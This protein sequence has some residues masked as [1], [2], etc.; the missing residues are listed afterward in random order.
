MQSRRT[1]LKLIGLGGIALALP[2]Y[3]ST[4]AQAPSQ[5]IQSIYIRALLGHS[6][7]DN[8]LKLFRAAVDPVR[9]RVFVSGIMTPHIGILD[10]NNEEWIGTVNSGFD[11]GNGL[12]YLYYDAT[13]DWLFVFNS[14]NHILRTIDVAADSITGETRL[15]NIGVGQFLP[16]GERNELYSVTGADDGFRIYDSQNLA[17]IHSDTS[18]GNTLTSMELAPDGQTLYLLDALNPRIIHYDLNTRSPSQIIPIDL[19]RPRN[20]AY[21][22]ARNQFYIAVP[23]RFIAVVNAEGRTT[24]QL[25]IPADGQLQTSTYNPITNSIITVQTERPTEGRVEGVGGILRAYD[26]ST[27]QQTSELR[28]GRK[29]HSVALNPQTGTLYLPNGDA[30]VVWRISPQYDEA[31]A[32]RLGDSVEQVLLGQGGRYLFMNSRL[33]GNYLMRYDVMSGQLET[34][35]A[36]TWPIPIRLNNNGTQLYILN[37]WDST[38]SLFDSS[39]LEHLGTYPTGLPPG[40]T[41]RLPDF[42]LDEA[43]QRALIGYPE[44]AQIVVWDINSHSPAATITVEGLEAGTNDGG[45]GNLHVQTAPDGGLF[46]YVAKTHTL[47]RYDNTYNLMGSGMRVPPITRNMPDLLYLDAELGRLFVGPHEFD[48]ASNAL[49]GRTLMEGIRIFYQDDAIYWANGVDGDQ[50]FVVR[51]NRQTLATELRYNLGTIGQAT[52]SYTYDPTS[53]SLYVGYMTQARVD[54]IAVEA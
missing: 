29:V 51:L 5:E 30:S 42:A 39:S 1:F 15:E 27:L 32:I 9:N 6:P 10:A 22:S 21:D 49:S 52:P 50:H 44:F 19:Q 16:H 14:T 12:K 23:P 48:I 3:L 46:A 13:N 24:N 35:T 26:A 53:R 47:L 20:F 40:S 25:P 34:F 11:D 36:G 41:D 45:P 2:P 8:V 33:G 17:L 7:A 54:V 31:A 4:L 37:F 18:M 28:F 38:I 43:R